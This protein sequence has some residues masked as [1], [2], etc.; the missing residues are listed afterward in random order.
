MVASV[1][2]AK[3]VPARVQGVWFSGAVG[4]VELAGVNVSRVVKFHARSTGDRLAALVAAC[5]SAQQLRLNSHRSTHT[6]D[7]WSTEQDGLEARGAPSWMHEGDPRRQLQFSCGILQS[8]PNNCSCAQV[9]PAV[10]RSSYVPLEGV[11]AFQRGQAQRAGGNVSGQSFAT[12]SQPIALDALHMCA[13]ALSLPRS[14]N[15]RLLGT[16]AGIHPQHVDTGCA[17]PPLDAL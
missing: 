14:L 17:C 13:H 15:S 10:Q 5:T 1:A 11:M 16:M 8:S 4:R 9:A 7:V 3:M 12:T 6:S 2:S